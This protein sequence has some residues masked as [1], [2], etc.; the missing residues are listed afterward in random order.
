MIALAV[1]MHPSVAAMRPTAKLTD[2]LFKG[3]RLDVTGPDS[4]VQFLRIARMQ[5]GVD[6][7]FNDP[8]L[9]RLQA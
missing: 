6:K 2:R 9:G 7:H 5:I 1:G 8:W 3:Y 4:Q